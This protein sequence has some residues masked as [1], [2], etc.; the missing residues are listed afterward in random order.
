MARTWSAALLLAMALAATALAANPQL[1]ACEENKVAFLDL[2]TS[3]TAT[4]ASSACFNAT[5][6]PDHV[7][8]TILCSS[9]QCLSTFEAAHQKL[10]LL[11]PCEGVPEF[12]YPA[13][14]A[15]K[16]SAA[17][18]ASKTE[19]NQCIIKFE[20]FK[21]VNDS[22]NAAGC[23][24]KMGTAAICSCES[25]AHDLYQR[26]TYMLPDGLCR[27]YNPGRQL[28]ASLVLAEIVLTRA[29]QHFLIIQPV[30]AA[31]VKWAA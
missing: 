21:R 6:E 31:A 19:C 28:R 3:M 16:F 17:Y 25:L 15:K 7:G 2:Y 10:Q 26:W 23:P 14:E 30:Q 18:E 24:A 11:A 13:A 4:T 9:Q 5:V 1:E 20:E 29:R 8:H 12:E 27:Q 22:W